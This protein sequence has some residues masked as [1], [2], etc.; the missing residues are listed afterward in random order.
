MVRGKGPSGSHTSTVTRG[1]TATVLLSG[2]RNGLRST[3]ALYST[4]SQS[5]IVFS[6]AGRIRILV[7]QALLPVHVRRGD[8][9]RDRQ[10]CLS[11]HYR[12]ISRIVLEDAVFYLK[13]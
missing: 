4:R 13:R 1:Q 6:S 8:T 10:E 12:I 7:G 11:Y 5:F 3:I 9:A 2:S